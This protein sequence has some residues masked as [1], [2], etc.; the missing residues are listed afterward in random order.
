MQVGTFRR[1][2]SSSRKLVA[3]GALL[4]SLWALIGTGAESLLW[5]LVLLATGVPI[6]LWQRQRQR[7][8][9]TTP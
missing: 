7:I 3:A 2:Y 6:H 4:Y 5:G 8:A 1:R 9:A